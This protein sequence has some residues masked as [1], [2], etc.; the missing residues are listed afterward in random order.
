VAAGIDDLAAMSCPGQTV[1]DWRAGGYL[2]QIPV[3]AL[4]DLVL[5]LMTLLTS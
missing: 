3:L 1:L 2:G 4:S 5:V